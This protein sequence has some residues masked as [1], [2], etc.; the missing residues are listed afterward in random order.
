M[1]Q[2]ISLSAGQVDLW[3]V[4]LESVTK[5]PDDVLKRAED[6]ARYAKII[7]LERKRK[8]A[9]RR[10]VQD[11]VIKHYINEYS[12]IRN[13]R[14]KPYVSTKEGVEPI[15]F[16][17]SASSNICVVGISKDEVGLDL[18]KRANKVDILEICSFFLTDFEIIQSEL[19]KKSLLQQ[20]ALSAWC[21]FEALIKLFG[22]SLHAVLGKDNTSLSSCSG[23]QNFRDIVIST[24]KYVCAITQSKPFLV[25]NI[26]SID[27][28][29]V[30]CDYL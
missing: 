24:K 3:V 11:Y 13:T 6:R 9:F 1:Q 21:R 25:N 29:Q 18:E 8:F 22:H 14:G 27:F 17:M 26:Y 12:I 30:I 4:S 23:D 10:I 19:F 5:M 20:I 16:S 15:F 2:T 7:P 28:E